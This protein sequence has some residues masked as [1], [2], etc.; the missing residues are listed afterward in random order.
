M[1][2]HSSHLALDADPADP[3]FDDDEQVSRVIEVERQP[4]APDYRAH[5]RRLQE[6]LG[7]HRYEDA[8]DLLCS[9][10]EAFPSDQALSRSIRLLRDHLSA[11]YARCLDDL[12]RVPRLTGG[13]LPLSPHEERVVALIDGVSS[14]GELMLTSPLGQF[15]TLRA[16]VSLMQRG[17]IVV[18][19]VASASRRPPPPSNDVGPTPTEIRRLLSPLESLDGFWGAALVDSAAETVLGTFGGTGR[20]FERAALLYAELLQVERRASRELELQTPD[21]LIITRPDEYHLIRP[22]RSRPDVFVYLV[23]RRGASNLVLSRLALSELDTELGEAL[24]SLSA[25]DL[26]AYTD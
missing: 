19:V 4:G 1:T 2:F 6:L 8:L 20:A 24:E 13:S 25:L 11:K 18:D 10:R 23:T 22:L 14:F 16:L 12:D 9:V 7:A 26:S 17:V 5:Y 3:G 15:D 21:D